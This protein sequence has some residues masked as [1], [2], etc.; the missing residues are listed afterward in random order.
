MSCLARF[1]LNQYELFS[2]L[3]EGQAPAGS[4]NDALASK[5]NVNEAK[6]RNEMLWLVVILEGLGRDWRRRMLLLLPRIACSP[7]G[8]TQAHFGAAGY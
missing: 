6:G 4:G 7:Q 5:N 3:M 2:A 8:E 1:P